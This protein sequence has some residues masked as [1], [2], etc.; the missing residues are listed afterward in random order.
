MS[1]GILIGK[2]GSQ[3]M[4]DNLNSKYSLWS[5]EVVV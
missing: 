2:T 4:E 3:G 5:N 1:G